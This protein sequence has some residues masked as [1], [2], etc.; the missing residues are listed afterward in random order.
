[1]SLRDLAKQLVLTGN[2]T[3]YT[4]EIPR[5]QE[6]LQLVGPVATLLDAG[7]GGGHYAV[8]CYLPISQRVIA[9][10][11]T[12]HNFRILQQS[13]APFG[14]RGE[15]I[16]GSLTKLPLADAQVDCI[17]CTQVLEH[18]NEDDVAAAE[19]TRVLKPGGWLLVTVPQPPAPWFESDH[20]REGY[21]LEDLDALFVPRGF[22]RLHDDHFLTADTQ[23]FYRWMTKCRGYL[24]RIFRFTELRA[25]AEQRRQQRPY[26]LLALYRKR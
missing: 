21:R 1:M 22:E 20:V 16:Q 5:L 26:G 8:H 15:A 7:A 12:D 13:L 18:I 25:T 24:P 11:Y 17:A 3:R 4:V 10:E 23:R 9:V 2:T 6:A 19:I 14:A